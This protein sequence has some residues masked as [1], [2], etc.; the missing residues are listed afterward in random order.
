[1][2]KISLKEFALLLGYEYQGEDDIFF[3]KV[4]LDSRKIEAGDLF[5]A[6]KGE[7]TNG[8]QYISKAIEKGG[9]GVVSLGGEDIILEKTNTLTDKKADT[10]EDFFYKTAKIIRKRVKSKVI[11]ITGSAGKTTTKDM[12]YAVLKKEYDVVKTEGNLNNELGLPMTM[13][14]ANEKTD[15]MIL[16]MGMRG[17]GEISYLVQISGADYGIITSIEPV[18]AELLGSIENIAKAKAEIAESIPTNGCLI[19]SYKDK[20]I[21]K[22]YLKDL[23]GKLITVGFSK[24]A[25]YYIKEI[26]SE[27]E[28]FTEFILKNKNDERKIKINTPGRQNVQNAALVCALGDFIN[29]KEESFSG[30]MDVEFSE[31]RFNIKEVSE[32]KIINDAYNANPAA[33]CFSLESMGKVTGERKLFVFADMFEL[34]DYEKVGHEQV[35]IKALEVGVDYIFLLGKNIAYTYDKLKEINYNMDHV[36]KFEEK[37]NLLEKL[38]ETIQKKDVILLK[39]SRGM[40]LEEIDKDI[41]EYLNVL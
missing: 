22:P 31:M 20:D 36:F 27:K 19:I 29:I 18:H 9:V 40:H 24:N 39:G 17:L 16:E 15:Y 32:V 2:I 1:M 28:N 7:T 37:S 30:L 12:L 11:G 3:N 34:G 41:K 23:K 10:L 14:K 26:I 33:T 4:V 35:A 38:K 8:H 13:S 5:V 6:I 25:D 21:L